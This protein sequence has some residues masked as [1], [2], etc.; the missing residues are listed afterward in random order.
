MAF[1]QK[2]NIKVINFMKSKFHSNQVVSISEFVKIFKESD[3]E[4]FK[5]L[6][7]D[8]NDLLYALETNNHVKLELF[9]G[10]IT[11]VKIL[12]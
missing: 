5:Y 4:D 10:K 12:N 3:T 2:F 11:N 9:N 1:T 7:N 8:M 6:E